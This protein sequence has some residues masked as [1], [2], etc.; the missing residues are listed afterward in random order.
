MNYQKI[1]ERLTTKKNRVLSTKETHH[2]IPKSMGGT[3]DPDN[4]VD[5]TPREHYI[6]HKLLVKITQGEDRKRM[7]FA[8]WRMT[9]NGNL[10]T[11]RDYEFSRK[12]FVEHMST[13]RTGKKFS[14]HSDE[15]RK[16]ASLRAIGEKN[17]MFGKNHT[18]EA[19][20]KISQ[21][22]K[23]KTVGKNNPFFGKTHSEEVKEIL[24]KQ[25]SERMKGVPKKKLPCTHC[26][27]MFAPNMIK[28]FH[29][30]N[31]KMKPITEQHNSGPNDRY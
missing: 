19:K 28:R 16:K 5:L 8:L 22:R 17:N 25:M 10:I 27:G 13:F 31:C 15:A 2:I 24:S 20:E 30:D 7:A 21:N 11:A 23:G 1:Y 29:N 9:N 6:A 12:M 18:Q 14:K 26:G 4:L 3:D